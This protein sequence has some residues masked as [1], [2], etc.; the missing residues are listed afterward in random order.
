MITNKINLRPGHP[1]HT[2][3]AEHEI[4]LGFL[5][6]LEKVNL[7]IQKIS[8][9][10]EQKELE[11][12]V[13]IAEHLVEAEPHHKREEEVLFPEME[14]RGV[15][16]PPEMM[17]LE[18]AELRKSKEELKMLSQSFREENFLALKEKL[19]G[20][21]KFIISFLREHILKENNVLYPM[22]LEAI[23]EENVWQKMKLE[24]DK[25]GYCCFTPTK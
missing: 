10:K 4:I 1:I 21:S 11:E 18:H 13:N 16:G 14:K 12:L 19:D 8:D 25:I 5:D 20:T 22:A 6:R 24:C 9:F 23:P 7:V 3:M 17:R 15:F 2:L